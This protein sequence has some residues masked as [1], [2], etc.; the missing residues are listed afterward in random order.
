LT[1][2]EPWGEAALGADVA[3]RSP[4]P[5]SEARV[6][7]SD[8]RVTSYTALSLALIALAIC[9]N[10]LLAHAHAL[11]GVDEYD[12]GVYVGTALRFFHG[13]MPYRDFVFGHP[14]GILLLLLP[15]SI[16]AQFT[17]TRLA[18]GAGRVQTA[19]VAAGNVFLL[20]RL[21]RHRGLPAALVAGF[22]L[23]VFPFAVFANRTVMLEPYLVLFCLLGVTA[24]FTGDELA[25][26]RRLLWA[27]L[28]FGFAGT[29]KIW[30]F[31]PTVAAIACCAPRHRE[32]LRLLL[33]GVATGFVVPSL[34]FFLFSPA[35]YVND[36]VRVQFERSPVY[37]GT[38]IGDRL[39]YMTGL[40]GAPSVGLA[41]ALA[42]VYVLIV[43]A[44]FVVRPRPARLDWF[45]LS[46]ATLVVAALLVA[47]DFFGHYA[48]F[49]AVFLALLLA[50]SSDRLIRAADRIA[51]RPGLADRRNGSFV[52]ALVTIVLI[53]A[54]IS[55]AVRGFTWDESLNDPGPAIAAVVPRGACVITDEPALAIIANRFVPDS[56]SCPAVV[57]SFFTWLDA[58]P[59]NPPP[60]AGAPDSHLV[61]RWRAWFS[62]ADY[63]ILS[64]D[65]FRIPWTPELR[66]WFR[67]HF[68][69]MSSDG[70]SV[71]RRVSS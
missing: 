64:R 26:G 31:F 44:A 24:M 32:H 60:S 35:S 49:S 38:G 5:P 39:V 2:R 40:R 13:V 71:Y 29:I 50:V 45:A 67:Q 66:S 52:P 59:S 3:N 47:P 4:D 43:T 21:V 69:R 1:P 53:V 20:T 27:G 68:R 33:I 62:A 63:V 22:S 61:A 9:L 6:W 46:S 41:T 15:V 19:F 34:P 54:G 10:Q 25:D 12:D 17:G 16:M 51:T 11:L 28:A 8:P 14:P 56:G 48:Y 70:A 55:G 42:A 30:A 58:D 37:G 7:W 23:A 36:V 65:P 18:M 57:D